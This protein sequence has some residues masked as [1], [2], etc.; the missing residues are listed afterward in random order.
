MGDI[1]LRAPF[2]EGLGLAFLPAELCTLSM[3]TSPDKGSKRQSS[4][5]NSPRLAA[6]AL[7]LRYWLDKLCSSSAANG[8]AQTTSQGWE[9]CMRDSVVE[10]PV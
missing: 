3:M 9:A 8:E 4:G 5:G 7:E 10:S 6:A 2:A 1:S